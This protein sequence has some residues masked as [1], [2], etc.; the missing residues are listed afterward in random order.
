MAK[1]KKTGGKRKGSKNKITLER[2]A[3]HA[4]I[5]AQAKAAGLTPLEVM[6]D[7]M[8]FA[9]GEAQR[10]AEEVEAEGATIENLKGLLDMRKIAGDC[11]RDAAP[12]IHPRLQAVQHSGPDNGP[13]QQVQRVERI[14]VDPANTD[15]AGIPP[16]PAAKALPGS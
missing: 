10:L 11:A 3:G 15:A 6:L 9:H 8:R 12:Y 5:V 14:I 16:A 4:E 2:E 1:G 7:N 13:I